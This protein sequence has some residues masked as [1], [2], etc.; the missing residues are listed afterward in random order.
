M[1]Y[2]KVFDKI[3]AYTEYIGSSSA[4]LPNLSYVYES[5][6]V[7]L[8]PNVV[9]PFMNTLTIEG[10]SSITAETCGYN[11]IYNITDVTTSATWSIVSGSQYATTNSS[12][13]QI[14]ILANANE[15]SVVVQAAYNGQTATKEITLTY[16]GG[17]SAETTTDVITDESGNTITVVTTVTENEDGSSTEIVES[18][19]TDN[20]GNVIGSTEINTETNIDGSYTSNE[21]NYDSDG[22]ATDGTNITGETNGNVT[23]QDIKYDDSGNTVVTGYD[24]DTSGNED[25]VK[26]FRADGINTEYYA[27]DVT[28]GFV[29]DI[30]FT[31]DFANQPP[32]QNDNHHNIINSKRATPEPWY[33]FQVRQSQ[34]NKYIQLGT[35]FATGSNSNITITAT[36]ANHYQGSAN[37][38]EYKLRIVYDPTASSDKFTCDELIGNAFHYTNNNTFPDIEDLKYIKTTIGCALDANGDPFRF[39]NI[40]VFSFSIKKLSNVSDPAIDCDGQYVTITCETEGADIYYRLNEVGVYTK[41][42]FPITITADTLV[43]AYA[44]LDS[45][46]SNTVSKNCLYDNGIATPVITCDGEYVSIACATTDAELYYRLNE[47]G[48]YSAYTDSFEITATTVVEAYAQVGSEVGHTAK[49][50]CTYAPVELKAPVIIC[51][52][53]EVFISC[54][55]TAATINYR[56]NQEGSYSAYTTSFNIAE[57]TVVEAYSTYRGRVSAVVLENCE[58][59]PVH[60]YEKDY[61]TFRIIS[62]GTICWKSVGSGYNKEIFYSL[63]GGAWNSITAETTPTGINVVADDVIRFKGTNNTYAGSKSNYASFGKDSSGATD[64]SSTAHFVAEGNVMSLI[65]GDNFIGQTTFSGGTY[66]FCSLFKRTNIESAENLILPALT[67]TNYCYRAM[68]SWCTEL[69]KAPQLPATTL[70][71]G[72]YWYMFE[73]CA[74]TSAPDLLA[75]TLVAECYGNMFTGCTQLNFIKCMANTGF[76][77]TNCKQNWVSGVASSGTFVKDSGVSVNTWGRGTNGIPTNWLVYDDVPVVP[78]TITYDGFSEIT[79]TCETQGA[80]IYYRLTNNGEY[81]AYTTPITITADTVVDTYAELG[82]QESRTV[83]QTCQYVSDVPIEYSNR[84]LKKWNYGNQEITTPYS[85]N[86]IDGHSASYAKGTFNFE[87]SFALSGAQPTYLWFQH[88][89]HSASIYVDDTLVEKH[90]GGY[91]AFTTDISEYVHSGT[92]RVK[93]AIKNNE[94]NYVAPAA[95]DFNFNATL[96]NVRLLTSPY[97]PA[98]EYGYD[99]FHITSNVSQSSAIV[100]VKTSV[101]TGAT[102]VCTIDDGNTN[103]Y[104][105][106]SASTGSEMEFITTIVNPHLWNGKSDPY[107]YTVTLEIYGG[108][109]LY[110]RFVRPYGLRYYEYVIS[111]TEKVGTVSNPYTGFLLNGSPYL[112]RGC[113]MHDDIEGKANALSE[114]DY[115]NTFAIIQELGCNF[116]RLAH[117][118]HPKEVY[119]RCDA[120]GIVVQTEGPCVNK[121]QS[122]M[123]SDYYTHL[124][125]QYTDMV[126]Q[127]YNH[128]CIFFWGLSNETTTDDKA[129][130]KQKVEEYTALIKNLDSSR[131]VGYVLAQSPGTSPSA[132]YNDP[133]NVDWFGC[134]IYVGWYDSP[135]SNTPTS[136]INTRL[137]NTINRVGKPMAYSEYGCGGTQHCHSDDFMTT[138]TRGNH[139]RHDIEYMMWLH[140]G[141]IATIKQ[142]PQLMFTAQWQLFDIAVS[143]RNEGYTICLDGE[144]TSVDDNLRRLNNKGLVERDHVTKKDTFYIYKAWW[145]Q[146]D[147]FV[148]ICGKDYTK[149]NDRVIKCYSNDGTTFKLYKNN[150]LIE[151]VTAS[152]NIV[153]FT[154]TSFNSGDVVRVNG[155][156]TNDTFTFE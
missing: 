145:N 69:T 16:Q 142:Y 149:K 107:L 53:E 78:P 100:R 5:G 94:G 132:Y 57:D 93:V 115:N 65:Y 12:N 10:A 38:Y 138:T 23:T 144:N 147:K 72:V 134:N 156:S 59:S 64:I 24:I 43:Q 125:G 51:D 50:T 52:G 34:T 133:S 25:G 88:A 41:Y 95:G 98:M 112:L 40:D 61:L 7:Y 66:N 102:V 19:V 148:H 6:N 49:Q 129:F 15:S 131:M 32:G 96:G 128:S 81:S 11:A 9:P 104:S 118:P 110:H 71:Q 70:A 77:T 152:D 99:G 83:S 111:D 154:A 127:H 31:I 14:T 141:H 74:I 86:A 55:T 44:E 33:G 153:T 39:S 106:S 42:T 35:Q 79:L 146:T 136:Q 85:V 37:V 13:G 151:T 26:E 120:L 130:G 18:L 82:G 155:N 30:H 22:N 90:W 123:P 89:D 4:V 150:E 135:N 108:N 126:N 84:D 63:N 109:D 76:N 143:N 45:D 114:T 17:S 28:Q 119:D 21:T 103:V 121:L 113:C 116:I 2:F 48:T 8:N 58:Y 101:P 75:E 97:V 60:H 91:A 67:L 54:E 27:L 20:E 139:E 87:T 36:T 124:T 73:N 140:E 56:L 68:F 62:G 46:K 137:N 117:Y 1:K 80:T 92:N 47:T 105:A 29:L 3:S 122:T